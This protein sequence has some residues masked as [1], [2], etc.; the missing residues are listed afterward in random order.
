MEFREVLYG[1][2][3]TRA[4]CEDCAPTEQ[5]L[6]EMLD[7][8]VHAPNACNFQSWRIFVV[9]DPAVRAQF[10]EGEA[11]APWVASAPVIFV[12]CTDSARLTERFG[13]EKAEMFVIQDTALAAQNL[14]LSAHD[15]GYG[16]CIIGA[17]R[18]ARVR[19]ILSLPEHLGVTMLIPV[20][21]ASDPIP[22]RPRTPLSEVVTF[23]GETAGVPTEKHRT[24]FIL[25]GASV[26]GTVIDDCNMTGTTITGVNL[27]QSRM[28]DV[29]LADTVIRNANLSGIEISASDIT[30][31]EIDGISVADALD[32]YRKHH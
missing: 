16:G 11:C 6:F 24:P 22:Q 31:M 17:F 4:F 29:N 23:V 10:V 5:E 9:T 8:A 30:K 25:R 18:E 27:R 2:C 32:F 1:R 13:H 14:L 20:G 7:A 19:E 15:M 26:P 3:S 21:K 28:E 12:M